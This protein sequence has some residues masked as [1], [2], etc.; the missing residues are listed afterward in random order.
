MSEAH[1]LAEMDRHEAMAWD[2]LH[3]HKFWLFGYHAGTWGNYNHLLA[4][5]TKRRDPFSDL[6]QL[7]RHRA[8]HRAPQTCFQDSANQ[9]EAPR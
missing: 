4:K 3:H 9:Q 5:A 7:S 2:A 6:V 8:P 1:L